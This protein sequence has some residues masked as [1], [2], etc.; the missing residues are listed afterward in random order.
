MITHTSTMSD[1]AK[2]ASAEK[3]AEEVKKTEEAKPA[4]SEPEKKSEEGEKKAEKMPEKVCDALQEQ[5]HTAIRERLKV[6]GVFLKYGNSGAPHYR[7]VSVASAATCDGRPALRNSGGHWRTT[8]QRNDC[9]S[10]DCLP[11]CA[12]PSLSHPSHTAVKPPAAKR[13]IDIAHSSPC[14]ALLNHDATQQTAPFG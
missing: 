11:L 9:R 7:N 14:V 1:Q 2:N 3:K 8:L 6:G 12:M 13:D 4:A 10:H 5:Y